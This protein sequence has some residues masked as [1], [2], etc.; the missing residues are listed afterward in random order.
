MTPIE[1][2]TLATESWSWL[3]SAVVDRDDPLR[4]PVAATVGLD[5]TPR[6]RTVVLREADPAA[7]VLGFHTD[8]RSAKHDELMKSQAVTWL[9][10]DAA[11]S[12]QVRAI[13]TASVHAGDSMA[14]RAW[15]FSGLASRAAYVSER[16]PGTAIDTPS[17]SVFLHD[18]AAAAHGRANFCT[19]RCRVHELDVLQLHPSGHRRACV[20]ADDAVWLAP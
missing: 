4:T 7:W 15:A 5:G 14:D 9:F 17:A 16:S 18:E 20:R 12:I 1:L 13:S 3:V 10:Y 6:A 2:G 8:V 19:V 11:R